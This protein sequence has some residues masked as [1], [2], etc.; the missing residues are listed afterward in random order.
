MGSCLSGE[1]LGLLQSLPSWDNVYKKKQG[2]DPE[3]LSW[4]R[5]PSAV[6]ATCRVAQLP[7]RSSTTFHMD[8]PGFSHEMG[9]ET[10][11]QHPGPSRLGPTRVIPP[12]QVAQ[13]IGV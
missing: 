6:L 10:K 11:P 2:M 7:Q 9:L 4:R 8:G 12:W 13:P 3:R 1:V 5:P